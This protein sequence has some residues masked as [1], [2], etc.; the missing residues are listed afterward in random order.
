LTLSRHLAGILAP[1]GRVRQYDLDTFSMAGLNLVRL[2]MQANIPSDIQKWRDAGAEE[3]ILQLRSPLASQI[4]Q[5]PEM[6]ADYFSTEIE[7][8]INTGVRFI[9][10]HDKP[11]RV[12]HGAGV[13]WLD[14]DGFSFWF[15]ETFRLFR[16]RF[17]KDLRIG[18]PALFPTDLVHSEPDSALDEVTFIEQCADA[19]ATADWV[20][21]QIYWRTYEEM[22]SFDGALRFLRLYMQSLPKQKFIV[23]EFANVNPH[24]PSD[25]RGAQ[26]AEFYTIMS[27]YDRI[28][29]VCALILRASERLYEPLAW[30]D[31]DGRPRP[32]VAKVAARPRI[33]DP[34]KIQMTWPSEYRQYNQ[35]YGWNQHKYYDCYGI[36]G[37]HNGVDLR[38]DRISPY[39]SPIYAALGGT[40]IQVAFEEFGYGCHVITRS[41]SDYGEEI[42]LIYAH[43]SE[44]DV[45]TG[46]LIKQGDVLGRA[47]S[48]GDCQNPHL[49]FGLRITGVTNRATHDWLNP[50]PY[51]DAGSVCNS[52]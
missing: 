30:Q 41:Y 21:V 50:R 10:I 31:R 3:F 38:V 8:F 32:L 11:N 33:P 25:I 4:H 34:T 49:H 6:F 27:Q 16:T 22:I 46:M 20:A 45:T 24:L 42:I 5:T 35:Y 18:F 23:T 7:S 36:T 40:V 29:G 44:I 13:S 26:Y 51:L 14:G 37:G 2:R 28:Q 15:F 52:D 17:G 12:D 1:V 43:L 9:E 47:G 19:M 39:N 48:T